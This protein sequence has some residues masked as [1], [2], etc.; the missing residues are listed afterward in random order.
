VFAGALGG[1]LGAVTT[2]HAGPKKCCYGVS[3]CSLKR[4]SCAKGDRVVDC[5]ACG[6]GCPSC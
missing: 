4:G 5:T 1:F 6:G 3:G 2:A